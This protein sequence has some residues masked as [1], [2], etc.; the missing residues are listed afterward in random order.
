MTHDFSRTI[1]SPATNSLDDF[2]RPVQWVGYD[3]RRLIVMSPW[4]VNA[5]LP[6]IR[7]RGKISLH[8]YAPRV[9]KSLRSLEDLSYCSIPAT[10]D[11]WDPPHNMMHLNL[12]AGQLYL[13]SYEQYL[14]L[15]NFLGLLPPGSDVPYEVQLD[16]FVPKEA[17][18]RME[19]ALTN[20]CPFS[21]SPI[22]CLRALI[23]MRRKAQSFNI[24]HLGVILEGGTLK[25]DDF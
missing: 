17:R 15:C 2:L 5:L 8:I 14:R 22:A 6:T 1:K 10:P 19:N 3:R 7:Q 21:Q 13:T 9:S 24:S 23:S 16:G 18:S 20:C 25:C 4:E 12:F 11:S